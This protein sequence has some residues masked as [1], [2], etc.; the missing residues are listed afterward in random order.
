MEPDGSAGRTAL[1]VAAI[2]LFVVWSS[3][4]TV[5]ARSTVEP[6][7][8]GVHESHTAMVERMRRDVDPLM[9]ERMNEP[10]W[11]QMRQPGMLA[12]MEAHQRASDRML[13]RGP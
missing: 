9:V 7:T 11:R 8:P 2:A 1:A 4:A 5:G 13:G 3:A 6:P 12:E 10:E